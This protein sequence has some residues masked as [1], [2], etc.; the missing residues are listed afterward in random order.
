[1]EIASGG[2][3][4]RTMLAPNAV[5]LGAMVLA[6]EMS[7]TRIEV[8]ASRSLTEA[9]NAALRYQ[10]RFEG[11]ERQD[12]KARALNALF[13]GGGVVWLQKYGTTATS[14]LGEFDATYTDLLSIVDNQGSSYNKGSN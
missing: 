5:H 2:R 11:E 13:C 1:M 8:T 7:Q 6:A 12:A 3:A 4:E 14:S 9:L 10:A